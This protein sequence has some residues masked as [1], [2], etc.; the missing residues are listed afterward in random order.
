[1]NTKVKFFVIL[2][3]SAAVLS[4]GIIP[5]KLCCIAGEYQGSHTSVPGRGCPPPTTQTFSMSLKQGIG[6]NANI[7]GTIIDEEHVVNK[8]QGKLTRGPRGCCV[9]KGKFGAPGHVTT[10]SGTICRV[11]VLG[12]WKWKVV[13]GTA[14]EEYSGVGCKH[15]STWEMTQI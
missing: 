8:F 7:W 10:F 11:L 13:N 4:A 9:I 6:C 1:M 12:V 2:A 5:E 15:T 3:L 14:E